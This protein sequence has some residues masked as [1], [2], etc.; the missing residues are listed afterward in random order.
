MKSQKTQL[1]LEE[2][3]MEDVELSIHS[4]IIGHVLYINKEDLVKTVLEDKRIVKADVEIAKLGESVRIIPVKDVIEPRVKMEGPGGVF[5]AFIGPVE[6]VGSGVTRVLRNTAVVTTGRRIVGFQEGIVDMSGPG[7]EYTPFS[8]TLNIVVVA[9]PIEGLEAHA[10]EEALRVAGLK[11]AAKIGE[12]AR[13]VKPDSVKTYEFEFPSKRKMDLPRIVIILQALAQG[14]LHDTYLYGMDCKNLLPTLLNPLELADGAVVS[15][16]CVSG[17][18][19]NTT[20]HHMN[21]PLV[22]ECFK[23]H[24]KELD[25]AGVIVSPSKVALKDKEL[26][27]YYGDKIAQMLGADGAIITEEGF[28]NPEADM[29]MHA[30][31]LERMGIKT[32]LIGDEFAGPEGEAE[33]LADSTPEAD[34]WISTGNANEIIEL[35]PMERVIGDD[36]TLEVIAGGRKKLDGTLVT[37]IQAIIGATNGL[38]YTKLRCVGI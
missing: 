5:P 7:A 16:N 15:G 11:V 18:D 12:L 13:E 30:R 21:N 31:N 23:R 19:K 28:G 1:K 2:I 35:P 17:C 3:S 38:G 20:Y 29:M 25:F 26:C 32:L 27:A 8:K 6:T 36:R 10:H 14:L 4:R 24:G 34:L 22:E 9:D 33:P 37:E